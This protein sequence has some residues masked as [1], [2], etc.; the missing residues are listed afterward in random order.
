MKITIEQKQPADL[1]AEGISNWPIWECEPSTFDWHY[2]RQ[3]QCYI[4]EGEVTVK[5]ATEEV[6]IKAGDFVTFPQGLDCVWSVTKPIRKHYCF[7]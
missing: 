3:E 2:D 1:R 5:T 4:L 7:S 6:T